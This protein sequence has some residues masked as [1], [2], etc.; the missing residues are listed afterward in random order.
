MRYRL[1]ADLREERGDD[2]AL[3]AFDDPV[4]GRRID[5]GPATAALAA[6]LDGRE[7]EEVLHALRE[8][9]PRARLEIMLRRF[10]LLGLVEE[11]SPATTATLR[12]LRDGAKL[13]PVVLAGARFGCQGSGACCAGHRLGPLSDEDVASLEA[14]GL[15]AV[16]V[17]LDRDGDPERFLR[18]VDGRCGF[19]EDDARCGLHRRFG[20]EAKPAFC[21][22]YPLEVTATIE[23]LRLYD[24]GACA[25]FA[26]AARAGLPLAEQVTPAL[27]LIPR[28]P[29]IEHPTV[30]HSDRLIY[31]YSHFLAFGRWGIAL[32][33][34][35]TAP[36]GA[37]LRAIGRRLVEVGEAFGRF[38]FDEGEPDRTRE[39]TLGADVGPLFAPPAE[40]M[41]REGAE[42]LSIVLADL[43]ELAGDEVGKYAFGDRLAAAMAGTFTAARDHAL[44]LSE[45]APVVPRDVD[46]TLRLSLRTSLFSPYA[47]VGER[48]FAGL[49]RM[50]VIAAC[51]RAAP[52]VSLGHS[53]A[54]RFL[55]LRTTGNVLVQHEDL[56]IPSLEGLPLVVA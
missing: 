28:L 16:V 19:L 38:P 22:L 13:A 34:R 47:L 29:S 23:G 51:A 4:Y 26:T 20:A 24:N 15:D 44:R 21:R 5:L 7:T 6:A 45:G 27:G 42:M 35:R 10:L 56:A 53:H 46:E 33:E 2:G 48:P 9:G 55:S 52:D 43:A 3:V 54:V 36:A 18:Q 40:G 12:A 25:T 39:A 17:E 49:L 32:A 37:T 8:H 41:E 11:A 31:D 1:R 30:H 14:R 50:A